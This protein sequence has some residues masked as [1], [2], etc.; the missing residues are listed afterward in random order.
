MKYFQFISVTQSCLILYTPWISAR[1]TSLS[2]TNSQSLLKLISI[3]LVMPSNHII[4]CQSLFLLPS[5]FPSIRVFSK[6]SVLRIWW[7]KCWNFSYSINPSNE[8]SGL[9]SFRMDWLDQLAIQESLKS[10][11]Q[12]TVQKQQFFGAQLSSWSNSHIHM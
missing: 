11:L 3:E 8:S 12:T 10:L 2:I 7:P 4:L 1:Q 9:I 5:I 6:E